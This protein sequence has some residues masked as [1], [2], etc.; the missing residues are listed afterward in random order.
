M[1][2][3]QNTLQKSFFLC[4]LVAWCSSGMELKG[5]SCDGQVQKCL[6]L[7]WKEILVVKGSQSNMTS[8]S[9]Y[10]NFR[11]KERTVIEEM[12]RRSCR[13][14]DPEKSRVLLWPNPGL[15]TIN[16]TC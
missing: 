1:C 13:E 10:E 4:G 3:V 7:K 9:I 14:C 6:A 16:N 11:R 12:P 5:D 2:T 15:I 8:F